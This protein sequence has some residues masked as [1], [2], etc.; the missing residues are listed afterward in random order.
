MNQLELL[1]WTPPAIL[2]DRSGVTYEP[3]RDRKRL[4]AQAAAVYEFMKDGQWHTLTQ[5]SDA[6][7]APEASASA[8]LRDL[9]SPKLGNFIVEKRNLGGGKWVY[10]LLDGRG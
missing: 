7:G 4:N 2:G 10:R 1:Q 3:G 8:R 5:I 6:T 9:R